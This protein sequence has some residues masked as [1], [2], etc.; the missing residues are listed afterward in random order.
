[1]HREQRRGRR[2]RPSL[3][4]SRPRMRRVVESLTGTSKFMVLVVTVVVTAESDTDALDVVVAVS[5]C[6]GPVL[7]IVVAPTPVIDP[8]G[9][10]VERRI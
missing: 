9:A 8:D 2:L 10:S 5:F 3:P 7:R 6:T 1:M 4:R